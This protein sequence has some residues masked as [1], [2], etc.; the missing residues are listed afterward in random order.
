MRVKIEDMR[1]W[2]RDF[3]KDKPFL[4]LHKVDIG[5]MEEFFVAEE[6]VRLKFNDKK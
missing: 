1:D 2:L 5:D 4:K 3:Y 6:Y